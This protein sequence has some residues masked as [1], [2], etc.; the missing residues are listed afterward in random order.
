MKR[1]RRK[2]RKRR[3]KRRR[4]L[5]HINPTDLGPTK[6]NGD[7]SEMMPTPCTLVQ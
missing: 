4:R 5:S 3:K 7:I 1:R 2:N 6:L